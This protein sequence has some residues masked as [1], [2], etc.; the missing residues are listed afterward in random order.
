ML[1]AVAVCLPNGQEIKSIF[2]ISISFG[3]AF[4]SR[5]SVCIETDDDA[6]CL[7]GYSY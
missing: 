6:H 3:L 2:L 1:A 4:L 7:G 5:F